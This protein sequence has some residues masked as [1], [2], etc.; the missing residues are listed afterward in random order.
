MRDRLSGYG[1]LL[2]DM[3]LVGLY[4]TGSTRRR[5]N[6]LQ[7]VPT[8]HTGVFTI[9]LPLTASAVAVTFLGERP[10]AAHAVAFACVEAGTLL[11]AWP[12][13]RHRCGG[14]SHVS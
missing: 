3:A 5:L 10:T 6:A 13:R 9:A 4:V 14:D 12:D 8:N 2:A 11:V 1:L 7:R